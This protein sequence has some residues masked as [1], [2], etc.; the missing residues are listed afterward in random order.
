MLRSVEEDRDVVGGQPLAEELLAESGRVGGDGLLYRGEILDALGER[1]GLALYCVLRG[2]A[3][4]PVLQ[5]NIS[6]T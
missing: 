3:R 5:C 4:R 2:P 1:P 6:R